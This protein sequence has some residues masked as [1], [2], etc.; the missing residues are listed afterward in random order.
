LAG[1]EPTPEQRKARRQRNIAIALAIGFLAV[2]FY[3]VTLAKF[4]GGGAG[5]P[6]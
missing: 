5:R 3:V 1:L 4:A 2:L 6:M